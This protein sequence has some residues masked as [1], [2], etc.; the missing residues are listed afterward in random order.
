M[1]S[2]SRASRTTREPAE[3]P[4]A[5]SSR[6]GVKLTDRKSDTPVGIVQ[7][8]GSAGILAQH[9]QVNT[10]EG[11]AFDWKGTTHYLALHDLLTKDAETFIDGQ[12]PDRRR[13]LRGRMTYIPPGCRTWGWSVP[14]VGAQSFTAIFFDPSELEE[15]IAAGL[16]KLASRPRL[17]F[18]D[19]A[20]HATF[21][22]LQSSLGSLESGERVYLE[23]LCTLGLMELCRTQS[24]PSEP[25]VKG[26][27]GSRLTRRVVEFVDQ[28]LRE[29]ISLDD[30][31]RIAGLSRYH[32]LRAFK[33]ATRETPY[34]L[35]L[36]R[37]VEHA[38]DLLRAG[39]LSIAEVASAVGFKNPARFA[40]AF[41]RIAH[42]TPSE[43]RRS[44]R[45]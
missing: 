9:V 33:L 8:F 17:Y 28:N 10:T 27:L 35:L 16:T 4:C 34:Q 36:R 22:K 23:T 32:F 43:F 15:D 31:S 38:Q 1:K 24:R 3:V 6:S 2:R 44:E 25:R 29:D 37:R 21:G 7:T 12:R 5:A 14:S 40:A 19:A 20:L 45:A 41:R 42:S 39:D 26:A 11:C 30:L 13:D 18:M